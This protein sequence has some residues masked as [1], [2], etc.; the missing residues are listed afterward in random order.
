MPGYSLSHL[1]DH[2]LLREL[3]SLVAREREATAEVL[4]HIAEVD[5]RQLYLPAAYHSMHAYCLGELHFSEDAA[6]KRIQIARKARRFPAIFT[7]VADGR[8]HL[9][10][11]GLLVPHMIPRNVDE[12]LAAASHKSKAEIERLLAERF[13][14]A[15]LPESVRAVP[16]SPGTTLQPPPLAPAQVGASRESTEPASPGLAG[17]ATQAGRRPQLEPAQVGASSPSRVAPLSA[18]RYGFQ[19]TVD[20]RVHVKFRHVQALLAHRQGAGSIV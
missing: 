15:D 13:P 10:G 7:A 1:A 18:T 4:A 9:T 16:P 6:Y 19:F 5:A 11:L 17:D 8:L 14:R 12:L 3:H 20:E 2:D